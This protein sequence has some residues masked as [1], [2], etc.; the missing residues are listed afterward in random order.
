[1]FPYVAGRIKRGLSNMLLLVL[2]IYEFLKTNCVLRE[3]INR[4]VVGVNITRTFGR[5]S[6]AFATPY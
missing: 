2:N 6:L 4:F 1:M 5:G 3:S